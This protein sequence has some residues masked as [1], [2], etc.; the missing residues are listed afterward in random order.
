MVLAAGH[1]FAEAAKV[2]FLSAQNY[3]LMPLHEYG[4][5]KSL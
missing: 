5:A 1:R 4:P 3:A 2:A